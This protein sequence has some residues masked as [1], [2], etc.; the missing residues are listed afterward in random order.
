MFRLGSRGVTVAGLQDDPVVSKASE[1][2]QL[3]FMPSPNEIR[4]DKEWG[5]QTQKFPLG[6]QTNSLSSLKTQRC[7]RNGL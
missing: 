5:F 4:E 6:D 2:L 1:L 3:E 7:M